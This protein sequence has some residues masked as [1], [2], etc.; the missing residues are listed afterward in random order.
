MSV[1]PGINEVRYFIDLDRQ[2]IDEMPVLADGP[3]FEDIRY[4]ARIANSLMPC[5][6]HCYCESHTGYGGF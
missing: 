6:P 4:C 1:C 3:E 5:L 2:I